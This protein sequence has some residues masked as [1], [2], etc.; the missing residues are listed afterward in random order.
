MDYP[1]DN[2]EYT[3]GTYWNSNDLEGVHLASTPTPKL[4]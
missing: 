2:S 4:I 3:G 1:G